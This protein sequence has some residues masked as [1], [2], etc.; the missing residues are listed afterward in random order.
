GNDSPIAKRLDLCDGIVLQHN[1]NNF[2]ISFSALDFSEEEPFN[3]QYK[4]KGYHDTW[5]EAGG[6][7]EALY[8]NLKPGRYT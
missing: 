5:V 1:Q 6:N 2:S 8:A 3:Y 4:L 7:R